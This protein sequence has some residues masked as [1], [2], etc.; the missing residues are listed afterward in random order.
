[1]R[2][3]LRTRNTAIAPTKSAAKSGRSRIG[4]TITPLKGFLLTLLCLGVP[5]VSLGTVCLSLLQNN[6][7]LNAEN[8]EL[9][10]IAS[11][12]KAEVDSLGEEIEDLR[13][14][15]GTESEIPLPE[16]ADTT[17]TSTTPPSAV[18]TTSQSR[19]SSQSFSRSNAGRIVGEDL[20]PRGGPS[21]AIDS[22]ELLEDLRQQVPTLS[23]TLASQVKPAVEEAIAKEAAYPSGLPVVGKINISSEYG[24]RRN[25]F[26]RGGYEVHKGIDFVGEVGNIITA[27]GDGVVTLA[28][29]KGGYGIAVTIDHQNGYESLYAHMSE[30]KVKAGESVNRGQIIGYIGSTGRSSG[31]HLHYSLYKDGESINPRQL[32]NLDD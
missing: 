6:S 21:E 4:I 3:K 8:Q 24:V 18:E 30:M 19:K 15:A 26:G 14:W 20:P 27:S 13:E 10:E 25:P 7:Q 32:L 5:T 2:Q 9:S 29:D 23:Q 22:L 11:E 31:P 12:V 17:P 1:M 28:G 16:S